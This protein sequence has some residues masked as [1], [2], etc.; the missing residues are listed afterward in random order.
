MVFLSTGRSHHDLALVELGA[1]AS[2]PPD[3]AL[4]L[5]HLAFRV[6][7]DLAALRRARDHLHA[8]DIPV[9]RTLDHRVSTGLYVSDP[10]GHLI[11]LYV[12]ADPAIWHADP[13]LVATSIPIE[14]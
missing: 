8:L 13:A 5:H 12:D 6:G 7:D 14:L 11:E 1:G 2:P 3:R 9:H 4:G 10:D